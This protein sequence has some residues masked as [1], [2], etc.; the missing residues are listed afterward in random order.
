MC[1]GV[2]GNPAQRQRWAYANDLAW[3][4]SPVSALT[5]ALCSAPFGVGNGLNV[6][7]EVEIYFQKLT[8]FG[9]RTSPLLTF[10]PCLTCSSSRPHYA[11]CSRASFYPSIFL[12]VYLALKS[13][14]CSHLKMFFGINILDTFDD[15]ILKVFIYLFGGVG[16]SGAG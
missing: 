5:Q 12:K 6:P 11:D 10:G 16:F 4:V 15:M 9:T 8:P 1:V 13:S 14:W 2:P 3:C 7:Q